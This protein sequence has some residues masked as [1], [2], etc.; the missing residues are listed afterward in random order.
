VLLR[1]DAGAACLYAIP[2]CGRPEDRLL[3]LFG[4]L[5]PPLAEDEGLLEFTFTLQHHRTRPLMPAVLLRLIEIAGEQGL[6]RV[7][8]Y[9]RV[10]RPSLIRFVLRVGFAPCGGASSRHVAFQ[11]LESRVVESSSGLATSKHL[12]PPRRAQPEP[13]RVRHKRQTRR[14]PRSVSPR[15]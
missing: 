9:V 4:G 6:R 5:F 2:Y 8:T 13:D 11:P 15:V 10:D 12:P 14:R 1:P 7:V 3:T